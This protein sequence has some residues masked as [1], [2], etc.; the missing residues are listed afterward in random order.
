MIGSDAWG[1]EPYDFTQ[2]APAGPATWSLRTD[3]PLLKPSGQG[4]HPARFL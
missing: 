2:G 3:Q 4:S 1:L